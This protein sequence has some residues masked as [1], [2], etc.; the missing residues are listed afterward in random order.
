MSEYT[1]KIQSYDSKLDYYVD[2][3]NEFFIT[4]NNDYAFRISFTASSAKMTI[5]IFD[6]YGNYILKGEIIDSN[7]VNFPN[8]K[9]V[10]YSASSNEIL[11]PFNYIDSMG[12]YADKNRG[13]AYFMLSKDCTFLVTISGCTAFVNVEGEL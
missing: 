7:T 4:G 13:P 12:I 10:I 6:K 3:N 9:N 11:N 2:E 8:C 1:G 5:D